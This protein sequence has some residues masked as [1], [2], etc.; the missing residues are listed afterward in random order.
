MDY[1]KAEI[2]KIVA[3]SIDA[4]YLTNVEEDKYKTIQ[5]NEFF[6]SYFGDEGSFHIMMGCLLAGNISKAAMNDDSYHMH[7]E[8][9]IGY[10]KKLANQ[11][12]IN[13]NDKEYTIGMVN[14]P[15]DDNTSVLLIDTLSVGEY[16]HIEK[17]E[18]K[19][20]AVNNAYLF[21]MNV[22]LLADSCSNMYMSEVEQNS[23][24]NLDISYIDWRRSIVPMFF[25]ESQKIFLE[26]TEPDFLKNNLK[27]HQTKSVDCQM[28]NMSGN[29]IWVKLIFNRVNT[30]DDND[31][32]F[33]F[34]I[35]DIDESRNLLD[36]KIKN[37]E[38]LATKDSLTGLLNHGSIEDY[39]MRSME[40][41]DNNTIS[42][43]MFDI[44]HFKLVNDNY[45][46]A[47]GDQVLKRISDLSYDFL[48][49]YGCK[50]GRWGGEEFLG[51]LQ[52]IEL[53]K[54]YTI[55]EELRLLIEKSEFETVKHITSS[56]GVYQIKPVDTVNDA[57]NA[58]D[59]NLYKAKACGR[60]CVKKD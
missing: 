3:D 31:F 34:M 16:T 35:E 48:K 17:T 27:Y 45:G 18:D 49:E 57:F 53:E 2:M 6:H 4:I 37:Y 23:V 25:E 12:R 30:G 14:Y 26:Y 13:V 41:Y 58:V 54:A 8:N 52:G 47:V 56:F 43:I 10:R 39:L 55:A 7:F 50:M 15:L 40:A 46:H 60:N 59:N 42:L 20:N 22:D 21:S 11:F 32:R 5:D 51:V 9:P 33:V 38:D 28:A 36:E 19:T 24:G 44:D 29:I 1:S